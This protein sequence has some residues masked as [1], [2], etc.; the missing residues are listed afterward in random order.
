VL[1]EQAGLAEDLTSCVT[2]Q[3]SGPVGQAAEVDGGST[4]DVRSGGA[5]GTDRAHGSN[6]E[7]L[8]PFYRAEGKRRRWLAVVSGGLDSLRCAGF[9]EEM[10]EGK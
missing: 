8:S 2:R 10:R 1:R 4:M 6:Q 7:A 5:E 9:K 3:W